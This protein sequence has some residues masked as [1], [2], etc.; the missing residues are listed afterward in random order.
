MTKK[1]LKFFLFS[2]SLLSLFLVL[3]LLFPGI[4]HAQELH[5]DLT[6][7]TGGDTGWIFTVWKTMLGIADIF[8]VLVLLMLAIVNIL[9][10]NYDTYQVKKALPA[11]I[12]GVIAANFSIL[13]T[14]MIVDFAQVLT[15]TFAGNTDKL[16]KEYLCAIALGNG[17]ADW[18]GPLLSVFSIILV[19]FIGILIL[20][21]I[22]ILA[23]LLWIRKVVIF[24]LVAVAPVAM[25]LYAFPPTQGIFKQWWSQFLKWVFM[26]PII[27][28][29]VWM[30]SQIGATN[31][32]VFS[33]PAL[34]A[35][36]AVTYL[37]AIVPFKLGGAVMGAWAKLGKKGAGLAGKAAYDNPWAKAQRASGSRKMADWWG[38]TRLGKSIDN[39]RSR[40]ALEKARREESTKGRMAHAEDYM[41]GRAANRGDSYEEASVDNERKMKDLQQGKDSRTKRIYVDDNGE[42][43]AKGKLL[44]NAEIDDTKAKA[45]LEQAK[46]DQTFDIYINERGR[47]L[48]NFENTIAN[49]QMRLEKI[50]KDFS[51]D[52][53]VERLNDHGSLVND[54]ANTNLKKAFSDIEAA[55]MAYAMAPEHEKTAKKTALE[56]AKSALKTETGTAAT[57]Y[58]ATVNRNTGRNY[59]LDEANKMIHETYLQKYQQTRNFAIMGARQAE[60]ATTD[61]ENYSPEQL[62]S[63]IGTVDSTGHF[64]PKANNYANLDFTAA[65]VP[66]FFKGSKLSAPG[67]ASAIR[68]SFINP[69]ARQLRNPVE[70]GSALKVIT[71]AMDAGNP[72]HLRANI[73]GAWQ[74]MND[75]QKNQIVQAAIARHIVPAGTTAATMTQQQLVDLVKSG[76]NT[77]DR[78]AQASFGTA[79]TTQLRNN[80]GNREVT[81]E[82]DVTHTTKTV[83]GVTGLGQAAHWFELNM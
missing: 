26:G 64:I 17:N 20:I 60:D 76:L 72:D 16:M 77:G 67:A 79:L 46:Q 75:P 12:G 42:L 24:V 83:K 45:Y 80:D 23:F 18:S 4:A 30:A 70:S 1:H 3:F 28:A 44:M 59:T 41:R 49:S 10:I 74:I 78:G 29:L 11:L 54:P 50:K 43:T 57:R 34:L 2:G 81:Y 33:L 25:I 19:I 65:D 71:T 32:S 53:A 38:K 73:A 61:A 15:N 69:I 56:T 31:C 39:A 51:Y 36:V 8:V 13:I 14:R 82:D 27:M 48:M 5:A 9:H 58:T 21:A 22:V 55:Q 47:E 63:N 68:G 66:D 35:V 7:H 6:F 62:L 37:A 52:G 40:E